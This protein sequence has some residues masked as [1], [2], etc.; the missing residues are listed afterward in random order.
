MQLQVCISAACRSAASNTTWFCFVDSFAV[1]HD[2][3]CSLQSAVCSPQSAYQGKAWGGGRKGCG[4]KYYDTKWA[5]R[6]G[7]GDGDRQERGSGLGMIHSALTSSAQAAVSTSR[8]IA[9]VWEELV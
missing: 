4:G 1:C 7:D 8:S 5:G 3:V 6:Q 9:Y 2:K